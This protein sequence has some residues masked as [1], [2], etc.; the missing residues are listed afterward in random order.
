M[1]CLELPMKSSI[2]SFHGASVPF[3][4]SITCGMLLRCP[5]SARHFDKDQLLLASAAGLN[6]KFPG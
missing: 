5:A 4:G 2:A 1:M 6:P 3:G